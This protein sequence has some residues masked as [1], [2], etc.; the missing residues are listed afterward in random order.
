V[1]SRASSDRY[2]PLPGLLEIPGF[3]LGKLTPRGRRIAAVVGALLGV[4]VVVGL[5]LGVPA[6]VAAKHRSALADARRDARYR[7]ARIGELTRQVRPI[8]GRGPAARGLTAPATLQPQR[9]LRGDLVAAIAADGARR[10]RTGEFVHTPKRVE[11]SRNPV[12]IGKPDPAAVP[13]ARPAVYACLAVTTDV[14]R[15]A[16]T[17]GGSIGYPYSALVD[18]QAGRFSFCRVSGRPGEMLIGRD[19]AVAVPQACGGR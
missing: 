17:N 18:F 8:S 16:T 15:S 19:I 10:A 14:A 2:E 9:V 12:S 4:A 6:I 3:L 1:G 11:C 7:A 5:V 13:D